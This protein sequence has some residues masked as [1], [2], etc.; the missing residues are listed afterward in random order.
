MKCNNFLPH[1]YE[2]GQKLRAS[3]LSAYSKYKLVWEQKEKD[4]IESEKQQRSEVIESEKQQRSEVIES[5]I[6]E[7]KENIKCQVNYFKT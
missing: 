2:I 1:R 4:T 3:V 6:H 7:R 5:K